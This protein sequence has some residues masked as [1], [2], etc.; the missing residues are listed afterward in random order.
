MRSGARTAVL[1]GLLLLWAAAAAWVS[2]AAAHAAFALTEASSQETAPETCLLIIDVQEFYFPGGAVPLVDP[3]T[4][5]ANC[6]KLLAK[7][8]AESRPIVHVGHNASK[9][10]AFHE[11]VAPREGETVIMKDEV[12]AF[13]GTVLLDRLREMGVRRLVICGMQTHMCVEAAVRAAHDYGF[14]C[15]VAGD[16]CATRDLK[17]GDRIVSAADV[18]HSTLATLGAYGKVTD[19]ETLL[20]SE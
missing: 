8:R 20:K 11:N 2:G 17:Y 6:A 9:G 12:N 1:A 19:T 10:S 16:A 15:V 7:F 18:H 14:E 13:A 3:E 4:A 5:S